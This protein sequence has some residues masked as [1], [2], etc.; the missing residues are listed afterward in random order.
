V[1]PILAAD[2]LLPARYQMAVS[3]GWHILIAAFGVAFPAIIFVAHR[4]GLRGDPAGLVLAQRW[5]KVSGVLFALGAVSGTILSFELGLLWPGMMGT[6]GDVIGPAFAWEGLAFFTEAIFLGIYLYGFNRLAPK[7]HLLTLLPVVLAGILG[8]FS[9]IAANAWMNS[10]AGFDIVDGTV[11]DIDPVAAIFNDAVWLQWIHMLL[12]AYMVVGFTVAGV[13]ALGRLRGRDDRAHRLGFVIPFAFASV[14]TLLQPVVGHLAGERL[15]EAQPSKFAAIELLPGTMDGAPLTI[16]GVL[17]DGEVR[18]GIQIPGLGSLIATGSP[19][20]RI[21]GLDDLP[22]GAEVPA[23]I[24]HLSFQLMVGIGFS[25]VALVLW[26]WFRRWRGSD[27]LDRSDWFRRGVVAAGPAAMT[28]LIAGWIVTEVGRQP[29]IVYGVMRADEA[30]TDAGWIWW[31]LTTIV[32]VYASMTVFG[33]V[34]LRAMSRRWREGGEMRVPYGP[35]TEDD[36]VGADVPAGVPGP[37]G[38]GS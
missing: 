2:A 28:A 11:T 14:A 27:L 18:Y 24:V 29:W 4:R 35:D 22:E 1:L 31:S 34:V 13:Y 20:A 23:S 37:G 9:V 10:P 8:S 30:V 33:A 25:L 17:I 12:A 15:A 5:A 36:E 7:T 21:V 6:F 32:V 16:G 38:G 3:L 19:D 26:Y